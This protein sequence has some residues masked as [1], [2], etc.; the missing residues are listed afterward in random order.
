M[1]T[2]IKNGSGAADIERGVVT[3][4]YAVMMLSYSLFVDKLFVA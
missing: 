2:F 3:V 1:I 4:I